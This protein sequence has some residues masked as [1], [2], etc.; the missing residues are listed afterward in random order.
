ML[1][2][3]LYDR[4]SGCL[5]RM[6]LL[7]LKVRAMRSGV[8]FRSLDRIDRLLVDLTLKVACTIR[9]STLA[10]NI[11]SV[12]KKLEDSMESRFLRTMKEV[13]RPV[14]HKLCLLAQKWG[15]L[16]AKEW[17]ADSGFARYFAAI[18]LNDPRMFG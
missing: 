7:R 6:Q 11:L 17:E 16:N 1:E 2:N 10:K 8:W 18:Y 4:R 3:M 13:G 12:V 15:N 5:Q 14:A 9:S